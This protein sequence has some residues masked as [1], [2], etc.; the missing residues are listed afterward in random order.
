MVLPVILVADRTGDS[1]MKQI[2][3]QIS[4][5]DY[6]YGT[7]NACWNGCRRRTDMGYIISGIIGWVLWMAIRSLSE[8]E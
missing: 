1:N 4:M 8:D 7:R 6:L 5:E 2:D 3:G